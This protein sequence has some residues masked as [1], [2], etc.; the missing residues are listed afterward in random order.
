[1]ATVWIVLLIIVVQR[2]WVYRL[3]LH[4][5]STLGPV[6]CVAVEY[7]HTQLVK[8]WPHQ[9]IGKCHYW[10]IFINWVYYPRQYQDSNPGPQK[11]HC[12]TRIKYSFKIPIVC[13]AMACIECANCGLYYFQKFLRELWLGFKLLPLGEMASLLTIRPSTATTEIKSVTVL[14]TIY[15]LTLNLITSLLHNFHISM[16]QVHLSRYLL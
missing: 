1:M 8:Y 5:D 9:F 16:I 4:R 15:I 12:V 6:A 14:K 13:T 7:Q 3:L 11:W 2:S 10:Q